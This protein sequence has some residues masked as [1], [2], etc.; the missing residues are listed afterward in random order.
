MEAYQGAPDVE[1]E[2]G[3]ASYAGI[4]RQ[5]PRGAEGAEQAYSAAQQEYEQRQGDVERFKTGTAALAKGVEEA[6]GEFNKAIGAARAT[7][8][9]I[10]KDEAVHGVNLDAANTINRIKEGGAIRAAGAP[11][12]P[13]SRSVVADIHAMEGAG[14]GQ[15]MDSNQTEMINHL[16]AGLRAQGNSQATINGLLRE[17]KD[18]HV[19]TTQKI[20]DIWDAVRRTHKQIRNQASPP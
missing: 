5:S 12:N 10:A 3:A 16:V 1:P 4:L 11:D 14:Q 20:E 9:G 19:D 6:L 2:S 13:L 15:R 7:S 17:M 8:S 18:M